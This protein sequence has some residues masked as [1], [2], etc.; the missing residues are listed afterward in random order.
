M[1]L[2]PGNHIIGKVGR[3]SRRIY[4]PPGTFD[5]IVND[6]IVQEGPWRQNQS[7]D[8]A[9]RPLQ[10][11]EKQPSRRRTSNRLKRKRECEHTFVLVARP[12]NSCPKNRSGTRASQMARRGASA[13]SDTH[14][15]LRLATRTRLKMVRLGL[16]L[17][18]LE[19]AHI[20]DLRTR[21]R[22]RRRQREL[23]NPFHIPDTEFMGTYC[24]TKALAEE[25]ITTINGSTAI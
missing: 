11:K 10:N 24:L 2:F 1:K 5:T 17:D 3:T 4:T 15:A 25:L 23:L 16:Q 8:S 12:F 7:S 18:L 21:Q 13:R 19:R 9:I 22:Q 6:E 14:L 20:F